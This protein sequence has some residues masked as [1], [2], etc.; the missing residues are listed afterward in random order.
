MLK[1][2]VIGNLGADAVIQSGNGSKFV[3]FRCAHTEK[4]VDANGQ[5]KEETK[6]IDCI[7]NNIDSKLVQFLKAGVKVWMRGHLRARVYSSQKY[8]RMEVG[9]TCIVQEIELCG[10]NSEDVP[11]ELVDLSDGSIHKTWK[12]YWTDVSTEQMKADD[13]VQLADKRGRLYLMNKSGRVWPD[14]SSEVS[15]S[16]QH[17]EQPKDEKQ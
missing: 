9:I 14:E 3:S 12:L 7:W 5:P 1:I 13:L 17:V 10:G 4:W 11:H 15:D 16:E 6:W 8:R 2:E